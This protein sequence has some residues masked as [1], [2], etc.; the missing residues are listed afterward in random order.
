MEATAK[1]DRHLRHHW[2]ER[3]NAKSHLFREHK[4]LA[5]T[6]Q[7]REIPVPLLDHI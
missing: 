5:A 1:D 2:W 7:A 6:G 3:G 4:N